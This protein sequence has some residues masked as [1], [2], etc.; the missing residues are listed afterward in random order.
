MHAPTYLFILLFIYTLLFRIFSPEVR[1]S[2]CVFCSLKESKEHALLERK[3]VYQKWQQ[4]VWLPLFDSAAP[5]LQL[6][7]FPYKQSY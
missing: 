7:G 3:G 5:T 4:K 1:G 2:M 6:H